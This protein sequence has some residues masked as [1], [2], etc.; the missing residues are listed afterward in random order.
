MYP[1]LTF[2]KHNC[3][4]RYVFFPI[5]NW[6]YVELCGSQNEIVKLLSLTE[7]VQEILC[8]I[9]WSD[10]VVVFDYLS[11]I[12]MKTPVSDKLRKIVPGFRLWL[13]FCGVYKYFL[14]TT[15]VSVIVTLH[16]PFDVFFYFSGYGSW[17]RHSNVLHLIHTDFYARPEWL[18][19]LYRISIQGCSLEGTQSLW[20]T[21]TY[22]WECSSAWVVFET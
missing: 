14:S 11:R 19:D 18:I 1:L 20:R 3:K 21:D 22:V 5:Q 13:W 4:L 7:N 10:A 8:L 9:C 16:C 17:S 6:N 15:N 2:T 12:L